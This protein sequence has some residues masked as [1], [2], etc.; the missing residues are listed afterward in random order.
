L[1]G[2]SVEL[3]LE[4]KASLGEDDSF[5]LGISEVRLAMELAQPRRRKRKLF[6]I[7]H[8]LN[9]FSASPIP[10]PLPNP[11]EPGSQNQFRIDDTGVRLRYWRRPT[12]AP[13]RLTT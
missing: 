10:V 2:T 7:V 6:R 8:V 1:P 11:Y 5:E 12:T 13:A 3:S 4:V 9:A